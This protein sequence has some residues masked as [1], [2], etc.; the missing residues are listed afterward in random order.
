MVDRKESI[1]GDKVI[2]YAF[3]FLLGF[4][5]AHRIWWGKWRSALGL[6]GMH[7]AG[8]AL[9][10]FGF[11]GVAA[12]AAFESFGAAVASGGMI[13]VAFGLIGAAWLW[14]LLDAVL[15]LMWGPRES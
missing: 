10:I 9:V 13:L 8:W 5:G 1:V 14:W 7:V 15:I 3:W 6:I 4:L 11:G 12:A 2:A